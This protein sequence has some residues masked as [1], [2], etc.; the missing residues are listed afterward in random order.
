MKKLIVICLVSLAT[1]IAAKANLVKWSFSTTA[2]ASSGYQTTAATL[3]GFT[4]YLILSTDW[5]QKATALSSSVA[6]SALTA[7]VNASVT[8]YVVAATASTTTLD[9]G[10]KSFYIVI[11][12]GSSYWASSV[13]T[14]TV[15]AE[16]STTPGTTALAQLSGSTAI[17]TSDMSSFST[18]PEPA[19]VGLLMLGLCA[20]GLKRKVA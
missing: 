12:D 17:K 14:G 4:A 13:L 16:G 6:S 20:L 2:T 11:S 10:D 7:T 9:T 3:T 5:N 19:S 15:Y 8:R 1:T 18:V